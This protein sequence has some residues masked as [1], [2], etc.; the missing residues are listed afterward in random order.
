MS[1]RGEAARPKILIL[2][3]TGSIG[4]LTAAALDS[5]NVDLVRASQRPDVV[6]KWREAGR[7]AVHLDL[8]DPR[9]YASA[10]A[11]VERLFILTGYT[12]NM[13]HQTKTIVDAAQ[14]AGVGFLVHLGVFSNGRS[15]DPH[16][17]WHELV[18]SYIRASGIAWCNIHPHI[19]MDTILGW[20]SDRKLTYPLG[21]TASGWIAN[22]DIAAISSQVLADGPEH[23]AGKELFLS[24]ELLDG[25]AIIDRINMRLGGGFLVEPMTPDDLLASVDSGETSLPAN[26]EPYYARSVIEWAR[27]VWDGRLAYTSITTNTV[28]TMLGRP[29]IGLDQWIDRNKEALLC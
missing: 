4:G 24:T 21:G 28:E 26:L 27:H 1:I 14:D 22:E 10:L 2:G 11:N 15:T 29:P 25:A 16:T 18:E 5:M 8:E 19:F 9:T 20:I 6:T 23:H 3:A 12:I 17:S 7:S 13:V